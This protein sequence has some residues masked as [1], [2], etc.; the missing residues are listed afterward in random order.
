MRTQ[1]DGVNRII[2]WRGRAAAALLLCAAAGNVSAV[3][4]YQEYRKLIESAQNLTALKDDLFGDSVSL[5]NGK[6]EFAVTDVSLPGNNAL[7]VQMRRRFSV[8]MDLVGTGSYNAS[9]D[10]VGGWEVDTP[11]IT[12]MFPGASAW[13]NNRCTAEMVPKWPVSFRLNEVWQGNV[14]HVPGGGDRTMLG[15]WSNT[16]MP[17]DGV[18][19]KWSTSQRDAIDCIPMKSGLAGEG[20]RVR[21]TSGES[22]FFDTA[23]TRFGGTLERSGGEGDRTKIARTRIYLMASRVEDRSGNWVQYAYN[24]NGHPTR[25]WSSDGREITLAYSGALLTSVTASGRTWSYSYG[26]V[27]GQNRLAGVTQPDGSTWSYAYSSALRAWEKVNWD[28]NSN[29][30]CQEQP[31]AR[32]GTLTLSIKHPSGAMGEFKLSNG[33]QY[34]SGVHASEC[35]KRIASSQYYYELATPFFYDVVSLDYKKIWGPGIAKPLQ[36]NYDY[37][38]GYEGLWGGTGSGA[39]YPCTACKKEKQ[40]TVSHPDGTRTVYRY[41]SQYALNE[42]R[43]L[44]SSVVDAAGKVV[45]TSASIYMT[46]DE[47][48]SQPFAPLYGMIYS[49]DE[50]ST[51]QVRPVVAQATQQ[52]GVSYQT[53]MLSFDD[54][55]R[56][57][58]I[59]SSSPLGSRTDT[60]QYADDR[61]KWILG[62]TAKV[63]NENTGVV[64][65]QM[66]FDGLMRPTEVRSYGLLKQ[67]LAYSADGT[68]TTVDDGR[69]NRTTLSGWKR[70]TPQKIQ[71]ADGNV[72][73]AV[74]DDNGWVSSITD[75]NGA[76]TQYGYDAMGRVATID[77]PTGDSVAWARTTQ[78][79]TAINGDEFGIGAGHWR[80]TVATGNSRRNVYFDAFWRPL[81]T[82]E[83]DESSRGATQ[84][85]QR[86]AYDEAGRQV[87]SS[88][89]GG[90]AAL[91]AGTWTSYDA[92]GR[93]TSVSVD[94]ETGLLT[95]LTS[96]L[97][98]G[99]LKVVDPK[100]NA[101]VTKF[102]AF[103]APSTDAPVLITHPAGAITEIGRDIF[104]KPRS[105]VRR[106]QD[107]ST[108]ITRSYVYDGNQQ[109]CKSIEP[110][111]GATLMGY[112]L[113]G[114]LAWSASGL[115]LSSAATCDS[116]A[117]S[118]AARKIV[119][120]YDVRNRLSTLSFPDRNGNQSWTYTK[121]GKPSTVTTSND[122]GT[123]QAINTYTY[124]RRGLLTAE[125][126]SDSTLGIQSL[127]YAYDANGALSALTYPSGRLVDFAPNALGQPTKAGSYVSGVSYYANGGMKQF[128][129][130][131]GIVHTMTQNM[132][133]LPV[134]VADSKGAI[135]NTYE[136]DANGNVARIVDSLDGKRTRTMTYD[137]LDRLIQASSASFGGDGI[138]RYTYDV[139]DNLRSAK[140]AGGK[141]H[142]YWH[143]ANNR[144]TN[145][146][147]SGGATTIGLS[148][149]V[150]GNLSSRNGVGYSFDFGNR[151]R[152]V[153]STERYR[154]DAH[155]R[156]ILSADISNGGTIRSLYGNDGVLRRQDNAREGRN[157]EYIHLNGS[158]V[159][160]AIQ[161]VAPVTPI[162]TVPAFSNNGAYSL[163]WTAVSYANRYELREQ[164]AGSAWATIYNG[165]DRNWNV[166]A[167][168][169]GTFGYA[170]RAC[171]QDS[172]SGWS[173]ASSV[174]VQR[175]PVAMA[176]VTVP[177]TAL[178]GTYSVSWTE[179][180]GAA[181]YR[182]QERNGTGAWQT[183]QETAAR[184]RAVSGKPAGSYGYRVYGCNPAGCGPVSSTATTAVVYPPAAAPSINAPAQSL[185]GSYTIAWGT[186]ASAA[187]YSVEESVNGG[188]WKGVASV[189]ATSQAFSGKGTGSYAY[190]VRAGNDA[191]WGPY[192]AKGEVSVI[193]P[194]AAPSITAPAGT[195]SGSVIVS[196]TGVAM[197]TSYLLDQRVD[198]GAWT[199]V[200]NDGSTQSQRNGLVYG[201]YA[202]RV[203][204][205][206]VSGCSGYSNTV[207]V[208]SNPPPGT[209]QFVHSVKS[210]WKEGRATKISCE[211]KWT[212]M[213]GA[214]SYELM[215]HE[216][217]MQYTGP[218]TLISMQGAAYCAE[219][220]I[221]RAC[222]V[223]GCSG[224]SGPYPQSVIDYGDLSNPR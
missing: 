73:S 183:I 75:E 205:C 140:L 135:D 51:A 108:K 3:E 90:S 207:S 171:Q 111:T 107:S 47:V 13:S 160:Q 52:D 62:A 115:S 26:Q 42:G 165:A 101:T 206:N 21:T 96:Y 120:S 60:T 164:A 152:T 86:F 48:K 216:G 159:A 50:P 219:T 158:L 141:D 221:I 224:W 18:A 110:E 5:Y 147:S 9:L 74:V 199:A 38:N 79:F 116:G 211:V 12:G 33:R 15:A 121:D 156:R 117:T 100:G 179:V 208:A 138:Y 85:Y 94:S 78:S 102:Q 56:P 36:W 173:A 63:T 170:V 139:V 128:T 209:P 6:T 77:W 162:L 131:N 193:R 35:I 194:P 204:A 25:I 172:C 2:V 176:V 178:N 4:P 66:A 37:G 72:Q 95:S 34:R 64:V 212:S 29:E 28:G 104:G 91:S 126:S 143:D 123:T 87:F 31:P 195:A 54:L 151:L 191:G 223:S 82:E 71:F 222:N 217:R 69:G 215:A 190:R 20:Y 81:L 197:A 187:R 200:Q 76:T 84:R 175:P 188:A 186:V 105:I 149:D 11:Y 192:S 27:E 106:N 127:G 41:G 130:G 43:L 14:I 40:V 163:Q 58:R 92:L 57:L 145:V 213:P 148:Y 136:Y 203:K 133:Q 32:S 166:S 214:T 30:T 93:Q 109:L 198:G 189:G 99:S 124:N 7:P 157:T 177:S 89:P 98:G 180:T 150:Q 113:A 184:N 70:G 134:R 161:V 196:W 169:E 167:K 122:A 55:A 83:Y 24:D 8:E 154:Y 118:I 142:V 97:S 80:Q 10:G 185:N 168:G 155:G 137:A 39:M 119:R 174:V 22:Y 218:L 49:G 88:H 153:A 132:R 125:T 201:N 19:R 220:Q 114:N 53:S 45:R 146:Q 182:L 202:Y 44:G 61:S 68:V 23:F 65:E 112:D 181:S 16:P 46:E 210:Q 144:L 67:V 129:Y 103:G 1:G 59:N 17:T